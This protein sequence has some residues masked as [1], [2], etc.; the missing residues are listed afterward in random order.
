MDTHTGSAPMVVLSCGV[1]VGWLLY[2]LYEPCMDRANLISP[3][4]DAVSLFMIFILQAGAVRDKKDLEEK[5]E[6]LK[7]Q[8]NRMERQQ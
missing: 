1:V 6:S 2:W 3:A 7:Q 4:S 8:L 5:V